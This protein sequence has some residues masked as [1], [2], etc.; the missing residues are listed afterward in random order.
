LRYD[1][2]LSSPFVMGFTS[3]VLYGICSTGNT[4]ASLTVYSA[5]LAVCAICCPFATC[6]LCVVWE[7]QAALHVIDL[8]QHWK[9]EKDRCCWRSAY[10]VVVKECLD[11][12]AERA[13]LILIHNDGLRY[14]ASGG[15]QHIRVCRGLD[16]CL[17]QH[18]KLSKTYVALPLARI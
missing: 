1:V 2:Q 11:L 13:N 10:F 18:F 9:G 6:M 3:T 12:A 4:A 14:A 7:N 5:V 15:W 16:G 8:T 17:Q